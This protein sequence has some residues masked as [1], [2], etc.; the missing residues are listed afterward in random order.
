MRRVIVV[1]LGLTFG[2]V[3][4]DFAARAAAEAAVARNLQASEGLPQ[5]PSVEIR[6][7]PFLL[8]VARGVYQKVEVRLRQVPSSGELRL[9][10]VD[11]ELTGVHLPATD[12][13][14]PSARDVPVDAVHATGRITFA[15]LDAQ[16]SA[17]IPGNATTVHFAEGGG[18]RLRVTMRYDGL[19]G[20]L[21]L[22]GTAKLSISAD[23]LTVSIADDVLTQVPQPL[24]PLMAALLTQTV[25]LQRLPFGLVPHTVAITQD[26]VTATADSRGAVLH[27]R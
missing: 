7:F 4:A 16:V 1:L 10:E 14:D 26:G 25:P 6:S 23:Q 22:S 2:L 8:Q 12:L 20:P 15:T 3:G 18:G 5:R 19:G 21:T 17:A 9:D 11:A 13:V 27:L 24:R